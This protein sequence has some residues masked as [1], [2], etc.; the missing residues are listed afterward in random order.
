MGTNNM[1]HNSV[2]D[3]RVYRVE[4]IANLLGISTSSAYELV[5]KGHFKTVR[6]GTAIRISKK[7]FDEWL[8]SQIT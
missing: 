8:D 2:P 1:Q 6:I 4:E 7:S 3:K 5:K